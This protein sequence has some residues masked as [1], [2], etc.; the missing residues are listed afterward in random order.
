MLGLV[1]RRKVFMSG[2]NIDIV[3]TAAQHYRRPERDIAAERVPCSDVPVGIAS[4]VVS[5]A[6]PRF[7]ARLA[8]KPRGVVPALPEGDL[9]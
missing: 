6:Q 5:D 8:S 7:F 9:S 2:P 1:S 4:V 3:D